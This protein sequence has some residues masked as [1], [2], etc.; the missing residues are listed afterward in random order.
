MATVTYDDSSFLVDGKRIWLVS[1]S[2]HYFRVPKELWRDRLLKAKR[3]G[4]NC[5]CTY[6]AWNF[7][8]PSEGQWDMEGDRDIAEFV[9][10]A[11]EL[12]LYVILRPGPYICAEWDFGGLPGWLTTKTGMGYRTNNA[13]FMHYFDKYFRQLLPR[14]ADHQVTRGGSII[15][16]QNEN[17]YM[18]GDTPEARAYCEFISQLLRRS[19][20]DIPIITCNMFQ[21]PELDDRVECIN[22][23]EGVDRMLKKAHYRQPSAPLLVPEFWDGWFDSWGAERHETRD[24]DAV[25]RR[26]LEIVGCGA[27]FN[28]FMFH[29]GTNFAFWASHL[30]NEP[31]QYQTTS[32]DY[33]APVA[34]GGG[35]T[36]KYYLTRLVNLLANHM[37]RY[38]A[39]A[40]MEDPG[41][42]I[43]DG[44]DSRNLVGDLGRWVVLTNNGQRDVTEV[45]ISLPDGDRTLSVSLEPFGAAA[46][47]VDVA[48]TPDVTLDYANC[49]P[50]GFF[51]DRVLVLHGPVGRVAELS[52]D[53]KVLTAEI[54]DSDEPTVLRHDDIVVVLI[55][56][57]LAMRTWW[58]DDTLVFGPTFVGETLS[59]AV[60]SKEATRYFLMSAD[61][62]LSA[63]RLRS[64]KPAP[65]RSAPKLAAWKR[66]SVCSEPFD[67]DLQ[68]KK[69]DRPRDVDRLGLHYGYVW[70]RMEIDQ[71]RQ[72]RKNLF[73]PDCADRA[74][75]FLNGTRLGVWGVRGKRTPIP[76]TFKRGRNVLAVLVDNLGRLN[77]SA[78]IGELKGLYGHIHDAK[79][80][81]A[82]KFKIHPG[83]SLSRRVI[84]RHKSH[85]YAGLQQLPLTAVET[86]IKLT[87]VTPI[88]LAFETD[89][90][91]A[92]LCNDKPVDLF[93]RGHGSVTLGSEL[94]SGRNTIRLLLFR[95]NVA[96]KDLSVF[97]FHQLTESVTQ[98]ARW[99][100]RPWTLPE[101]GGRVVGKDLPAW[102]TTT[103]KYMPDS[104]PLFV[105]IVGAKK[106]QLFLNGRNLGRFWTIGPQQYY[107]MPEC[108][109]SER[110]ELSLFDEGGGNPSGSQ[111]AFR[112]LGPFKD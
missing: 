14:L 90:A 46:I 74:T 28:Y 1:G 103:F 99:S 44:T 91:V 72:V 30:A 38:L 105:H 55:S 102:Y 4:L 42:W 96:V 95:E 29:G 60:C 13:A 48:L 35:L 63:K 61:G 50:L 88:H 98:D 69:L 64:D 68:W 15:L 49:M 77:I 6:V 5:I 73:L 65:K 33:D 18:V 8:E 71:A 66:L 22:A 10:L 11:G 56:S 19:G 104:R 58:V 53:G 3:A 43:H 16:I 80:V 17:E 23:W 89:C 31:D 21:G 45:S 85:L 107:Y 2:I 101:P 32:Y 79:S 36:D 83:E 70:Y 97:K 52:L 109:L 40:F 39:P 94:K 12:G 92:V 112:T 59:D 20:F 87:K 9:R 82:M 7:H 78:D 84:P 57:D 76:A 106:G 110:N 67:D 24:D 111:L 47:P 51:A 25:A 81:P 54:P 34:E 108:W 62:E 93:D 26:A 41:V 100:F 86:D 75:L 37:G 27:Q